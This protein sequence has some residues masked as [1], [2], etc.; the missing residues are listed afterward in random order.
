MDVEKIKDTIVKMIKDNFTSLDDWL[1][2]GGAD[3][4]DENEIERIY[5]WIDNPKVTI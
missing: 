5:K 3:D 1:G 2:F 4:L